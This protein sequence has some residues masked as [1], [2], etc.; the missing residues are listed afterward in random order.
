MNKYKLVYDPTD[1][2]GDGASAYLRAGTDGDRISSTLVGGKEGIDAY[3]I[4]AS[5]TVTATDLDIRDLNH[6]QDNVAIAQGGNTMTVNPDGSINVN[7]DIDVINGA[8]KAEDAAHA[9]GDIGQYVLSVRQDA[10][11]ASTSADGDYAS[12]KTD[13]VGALW[14]RQSRPAAHANWLFTSK[15]VN[16]TAS[17]AVAADLSN[18]TRIV[19]Q[20]QS[21]NR[22]IWFGHDNTVTATPG[23]GFE[24]PPGGAFEVE[25]AAGAAIYVITSVGTAQLGVGEFA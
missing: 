7:A 15:I 14:V 23:G 11:V 16:N 8:E 17:L 6:A 24:L 22:T 3:I 1:D 2:I 21:T 25:L 9:S 20:N 18:R 19:L 12:F 4:N 13:S 5:L 10:L